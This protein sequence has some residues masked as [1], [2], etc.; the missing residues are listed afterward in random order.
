MGMDM[1]TTTEDQLPRLRLLQLI[2]PSLPIGAFTYS[3]GLEWAV[4]S[5]WI[6]SESELLEWTLDLLQTSL[7]HL[8]VPC[9]ARLYHAC[10]ESDDEALRYWSDYLIASR[11][12]RE[13]R[14]EEHNR[15]RALARLLPE[16]GIPV[17]T[18]IMP[19]LKHCQL[20][21]FAYAAYH[22][23]IPLR[24]AAEGYL[25]G[26]L[27]NIVLAGV[28]I[29]PLGQSSGQR[30]IAALTPPIPAMVQRGLELSDEC[31]GASCPAQALASSQHETQYTRIYRS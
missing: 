5:G 4:E 24:S 9:L 23:R 11:E 19:L 31:I 25:W 22:W 8:E 6:K 17:S 27:E 16:I 26:W 12:T 7:T 14:E 1:I 15:G 21:G 2:S 28:K 13:L 10:A 30:I 18:Q 3:Q 29:V 20:A